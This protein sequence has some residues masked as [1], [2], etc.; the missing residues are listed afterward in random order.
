MNNLRYLPAGAG[1][2]LLL[3][4]CASIGRPEGGPRD[5]EPPVYAGSAPVPGARNVHSK[6]ISI[7]FDENVQLDNP[8]SK[9][10]IS[11]TQLTNPRI[12]SN[13]RRVDIELEDSLIPNTTYT[14]DLADAVKDLNEGNPLDGFAID[15]STGAEIDTLSISGMVL[16]G[17]DLEPAQGML[18]GVYS[19]A[20]DS[21]I[22]TTRF[23][24]IAR[25]NQLGQFTVRNLAPGSYQLF[26]LNDLNRDYHWDRTEDVAF[27]GEL[28]SPS[29]ETVT[30]ADSV[31]GDS[32]VTR[33]LPD[34]VLLT[35]FN[36]D[37]KAQY[38]KEY[39][40]KSRNIIHIETGAPC[41]SLPQLTLVATGKADGLRIPFADISVL[42]R[43]E[44]ADTLDFWLTDSAIIASDTLLVETR[45]RRTDSLERVVWHTDTL[46]F[47]IRS[48]KGSRPPRKLTLQEKIDS[49]LA[50]SD[51]VVI[52]T[53]A[54]MQ[55]DTWLSIQPAQSAQ[56]LNK[57]FA[58][59]AS[60]PI[61]SMD[62]SG[63]RLEITV[64][65]VWT[66]VEPQPRVEFADSISLRNLRLDHSWTPGAAYRLVIDSM[67]VT[68]I[69]GAYNKPEAFEFNA[70]N[71]DDYSTIT[72]ALS[73]LP[74][75]VGAV[76]ELLDSSDNPVLA[77]PV[78]GT[79]VTLDYLLPATYYAR[80]F[81]DRNGDGLWTN[82]NLLGRRQPEDVYYF[83]KKLA[84]KKNWDRNE[85][86][87]I[88]ALPADMQK[89]QEI[90]TNKP[91]PKPGELPETAPDD[92]DEEY[93]TEGFGTNHFNPNNR[94]RNGQF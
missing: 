63:I 23:N 19:S 93:D 58:L 92:E 46:K 71:V 56:D 8:G 83:P 66:P 22:I 30:V 43:N 6:R 18:V 59:S 64:D 68:D 15:F 11:P 17:R 2:A 67:A 12:S 32:T 39:N 51:T 31:A 87:D 7:F 91:K 49:L 61:R 40:R 36:E 90:K 82:G 62:R 55:P 86:W 14:I 29:V 73:G 50:K 65:S 60:T 24:R 28:I 78:S 45:Y 94:N 77:K 79:T 21:C 52:D 1:A 89:P 26:A 84:V 70:R 5:I 13:G 53:F 72:F 74:D 38:L 37:Y 80:L 3:A 33:F 34:N 44:Q 35:W 48:R 25:T 76:V 88:N 85:A 9:V 4:A 75:S 27:F 42:T 81:I 41:D 16:H 20:A 10:A 54:L 69:Y 57:P 47:N